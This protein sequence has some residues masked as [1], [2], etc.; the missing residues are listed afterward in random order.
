MEEAGLRLNIGCGTK[1]LKDWI[2]LDIMPGP[3]VDL[4]FDL[5][6][7]GEAALPL[8]S[9]SVAE[10]RASHVLEHIQNVLPMMQEM[11]RVARPDARFRAATPHIG[12]DDAW[13]DPTH[14]RAISL[15][16]YNYFQQ[17]FY[18]FADYGY[19]GD[20]AIEAVY[21]KVSRENAQ[22]G[23]ERLLSRIALE[24]NIVREMIADLRAVKPTRARDRSLLSQPNVNIIL[25]D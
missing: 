16:S 24:R 20:W 7:C 1:V 15:R 19:D 6:T 4:V 21:Y 9:D 23:G 2:N 17:P 10:F 13:A 18:T 5:E 11:H 25:V 14:R 12:H 8:E 3:G 22:G